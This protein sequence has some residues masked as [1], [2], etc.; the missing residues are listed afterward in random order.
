[1]FAP[2]FSL[3]VIILVGIIV[4]VGNAAERCADGSR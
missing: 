2:V 1:M 3:G 4:V